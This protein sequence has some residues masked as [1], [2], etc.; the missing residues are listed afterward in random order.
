MRSTL[1]AGTGRSTGAPVRR[2]RERR[3]VEERQPP[4]A[5]DGARGAGEAGGGRFGR[6]GRRP[7]PRCPPDRRRGRGGVLRPVPS[8]VFH[9]LVAANGC[10]SGSRVA[11]DAAVVASPPGPRRS[12]PWR[13]REPARRASLPEP[14]PEPARV[15]LEADDDEVAVVLL[16]A[17]PGRR[18]GAAEPLA[19][20]CHALVDQVR[21]S[22]RRGH[23]D[24]TEGTGRRGCLAVRDRGE[25]PRPPG[26]PT[27][28]TGARTPCP[29]HGPGRRGE[30]S[31]CLSVEQAVEARRQVAVVQ[32]VSRWV[33]RVSA[34]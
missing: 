28:A 33:G 13:G 31:R 11:A 2:G 8:G 1:R 24:A 16:T 15:H 32:H 19:R 30:T 34:T 21:P 6:T 26:R 9:G 18:R 22:D 23:R 4:G 5:R 29:D 17:D 3:C 27:S 14:R 12:R 25:R 7:R 20:S 10:T